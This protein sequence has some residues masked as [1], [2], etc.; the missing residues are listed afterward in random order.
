MCFVGRGDG[1]GARRSGTTAPCVKRAGVEVLER[2]TVVLRRVFFGALVL[3]RRFGALAWARLD[4]RLFE[5]LA[6]FET[7]ATGLRDV[8]RNLVFSLCRDATFNCFPLLWI[9]DSGM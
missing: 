8:R 9:R 5:R 1:I 4:V 2:E 7:L 3:A 6:G